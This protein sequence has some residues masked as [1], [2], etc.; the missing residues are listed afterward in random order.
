MMN[1]KQISMTISMFVLMIHQLLLAQLQM[2]KS[3]APVLDIDDEKTG[4]IGQIG[5]RNVLVD[6]KPHLQIRNI[7]QISNNL[8]SN[9]AFFF[10]LINFFI[11]ILLDGICSYHV[12]KPNNEEFPFTI[13]IKDKMTGEAV[14][15]VLKKDLDSSIVQS[16][17]DL[18][19]SSLNEKK[20]KLILLDCNKRKEFSFL[21]QAH[22]CSTPSL[23]SNKYLF[24]FCFV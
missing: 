14:I 19:D 10:N 11:F 5:E 8:N 16:V 1:M 2:T 6:L 3:V 20:Q 13:D 12:F 18:S 21:I 24:S 4:Y 7:D 23:P 9:M 22:D 15:E 17:N